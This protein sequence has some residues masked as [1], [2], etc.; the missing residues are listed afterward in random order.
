MAD[1]KRYVVTMV[2]DVL[3]Q[4][5]DEAEVNEAVRMAV[6]DMPGYRTFTVVAN[7]QSKGCS[8]EMLRLQ[9]AQAANATERGQS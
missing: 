6:E 8:E 4:G 2:L 5:Q 3:D 7:D 1:K 9:L